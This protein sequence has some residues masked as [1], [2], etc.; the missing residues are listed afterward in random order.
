MSTEK[1][2]AV[3]SLDLSDR[4]LPEKLVGKQNSFER[5]RSYFHDPALISGRTTRH[6]ER[7]Y[8]EDPPTGSWSSNDVKGVAR[9]SITGSFID[10]LPKANTAV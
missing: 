8:R 4:A 5:R 9:N 2:A 6:A 10:S 1:I 3:V 7:L